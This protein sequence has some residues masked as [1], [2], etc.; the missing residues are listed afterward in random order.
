MDAAPSATTARAPWPDRLLLLVAVAWAVAAR[1]YVGSRHHI[2]YDGFWHVFIAGREDLRTMWAECLQ[3]AHPPLYFLL[4]RA[5]MKLGRSLLTYR[6]VSIAA[7]VAAVPLAW[8]AA[9]RLAASRVS[10]ALAAA[11]MAAASSAVAVSCEVRSYALA[12]AFLLAALA[13]YPALAALAPGPPAWKAR[14]IFAGAM[15]G[16]L[17]SHYGAAFFLLAFL[18]APLVLAA[19]APGYRRALAS[20]LRRGWAADLATLAAPAAILVALA[21][22]HVRGLEVRFS[23]LAPY[24]HEPGREA[25][26]A[27]LARNLPLSLARFAPA[28]GP[29]A[30]R[31]FAAAMM[32]VAAGLVLAAR[33]EGAALRRGLPAALLLLVL[34]GFAAASLRGLYP[35]GGELRQQYFLFPLVLLTGLA[36][37]DAAVGGRWPRR[38]AALAAAAVALVWAPLTARIAAFYFPPRAPF[39]REVA[40]WARAF[41]AP[42]AV[43]VDQFNLIGLF[44]FHHGWSW[45][46]L[47]WAPDPPYVERFEVSRPG[48]RM[49]VLRDRLRWNVDLRR[50]DVYRD[51]RRVLASTGLPSTTLLAVNQGGWSRNERQEERFRREIETKARAAGLEVVGLTVEGR[52]VYARFRLNASGRS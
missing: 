39:E 40:A 31:V 46:P 41:P 18:G 21:L 30:G 36:A 38:Q 48:E 23:H 15:S 6:L 4:L 43:Y 11:G 45:R 13:V 19:V 33:R 2:G 47:S 25:V 3:N 34:G 50:G 14:A 26:L 12:V 44:S 9:R 8:M 35:L 51:V 24:Y 16:A 10:A 32:A 5:S 52:H 1:V 22:T 37:L 27:F 17:L 28:G 7:G 20:R 29:I 42:Q 49:I